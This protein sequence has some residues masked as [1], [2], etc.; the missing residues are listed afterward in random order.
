M[1]ASAFIG[2]RCTKNICTFPL[3][4]RWQNQWQQMVPFRFGGIIRRECQS[5]V[6]VMLE[7][8]C[9]NAGLLIQGA[10]STRNPRIS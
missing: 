9:R 7:V 8:I 1:S 10:G 2:E 5:A 4:K 3:R 6:F